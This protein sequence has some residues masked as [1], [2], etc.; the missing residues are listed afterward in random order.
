MLIY[1]G[2]SLFLAGLFFLLGGGKL[3]K[4]PERAAEGKKFAPVLMLIGASSVGLAM[5]LST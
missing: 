3:L 4:D 2:T 5:F 1:G